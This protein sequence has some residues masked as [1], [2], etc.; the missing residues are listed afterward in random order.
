[1]YLLFVPLLIK[2]LFLSSLL[3]LTLIS[4]PLFLSLFAC[5]FAF[6]IS[7]WYRI[8]CDNYVYHRR[9]LADF[10]Q[11]SFFDI[12]GHLSGGRNKLASSFGYIVPVY[13]AF[14]AFTLIE[15]NSPGR[16]FQDKTYMFLSSW[17]SPFLRTQL[18]TIY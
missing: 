8:N 12:S 5:V 3:L 15:T 6:I 11:K 17:F 13:I 4:T 10:G 14:I 16:F 9:Q 7:Y 2:Y 1:M 18:L